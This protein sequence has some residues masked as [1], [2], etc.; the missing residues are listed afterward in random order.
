MSERYAIFCAD[1]LNARSAEPDFRIEVEAATAAGFTPVLLDHDALDRHINP[2]AALRKTRLTQPGNAV[3]RGWML[4]VEAYKALHDTLLA[5]GVEPYTTPAA[6]AACHHAPN[7]YELLAKFMPQTA[8]I[9]Q[10]HLD[11]RDAVAAV[12]TRFGRSPLVIKDWVKPQAGYWLEACYIP[13]AGDTDHARQI[14]SRF[15]ELQ[16]QS[17]VGG[18]VF[19]TYKPLV[20]VGQPADEYRAFVVGGRVVGCWPR[21]DAAAQR[22][23]PPPELIAEVAASV[24]NPFASADFGLDDQGRW[25]L[26]EVGDGQVSGLPNEQVAVPL[27]EALAKLRAG[28]GMLGNS[29]FH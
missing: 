4:R 18:V 15:I 10:E 13:D 1:P 7:S 24:P 22:A 19:K 6:Y 25:W 27:Y 21:S 14:I 23:A 5:R 11:D 9:A 12:L 20:P 26:L 3:Y 8:W 2:D 29:A 16:G 17:L 28:A